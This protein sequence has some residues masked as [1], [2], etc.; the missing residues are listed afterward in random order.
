MITRS[1]RPILVATGALT[2][3]DGIG[4]FLFPRNLFR[5]F[6]GVEASGEAVTLVTRHWAWLGFLLGAL[7]VY[8]AFDLSLRFSVVVAATLEKIIFAGLVFTSLPNKSGIAKCVAAGDSFMAL[9][10]VLCLSGF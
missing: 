7:L 10:Y 2:A 9:L 1:I 6:F 3:A 8:A 4:G 5:L